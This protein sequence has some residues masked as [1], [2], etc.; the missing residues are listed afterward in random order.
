M[1]ICDNYHAKVSQKFQ[2]HTVQINRPLSYYYQESKKFITVSKR[3]ELICSLIDFLS[4]KFK[5]KSVISKSKS[6]SNHF[7]DTEMIGTICFVWPEIW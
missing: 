2:V 4:L 1:N 7:I 5:N 3:L 6:K